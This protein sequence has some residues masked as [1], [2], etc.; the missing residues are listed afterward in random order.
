VCPE[1][2]KTLQDKIKPVCFKNTNAY[3]V[4]KFTDKKITKTNKTK[5]THF[6]QTA[7]CSTPHN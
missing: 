6:D 2:D 1:N 4:I 5:L 3:E 7:G